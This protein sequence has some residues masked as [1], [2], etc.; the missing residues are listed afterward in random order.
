MAATLGGNEELKLE[1]EEKPKVQQF[2]FSAGRL[3]LVGKKM[4]P[5]PPFAE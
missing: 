3:E 2:V 5:D 4:S 1:E